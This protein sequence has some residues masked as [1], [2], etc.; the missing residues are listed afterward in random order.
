VVDEPVDLQPVRAR[1][2]GRVDPRP[3]HHDHPQVRHGAPGDRER[4]DHP[5]Q[6]LGAGRRPADRGDAERRA[7]RAGRDRPGRRSDVAGEVEV[8]QRPVADRR[9]SRAERVG[10]QVVRVADEDRPVAQPRVP[11]DVLHHLGVVV[12]G[13]LGLPG[14][15][16]RHRQPADEVG[17]PR[18]RRPL[19]GRV[20][21]QEMVELPGLVADPQVVAFLGDQV[22]EQHEVADQDRV[23]P[24]DRLERVQVVHAGLGVDVRRLGRQ[25]PRGRVHPLAAAGQHLGRR[26]LGQPVHFDAGM[27]PAQRPDDR[28]VALDVAQP[29]RRGQEEHPL[30]PPSPR[31]GGR[32]GRHEVAQQVVD[33]DRPPRV[34]QVPG[35][36]QHDLPRPGQLGHR[37]HLRLRPAPVAVAPDHQD[38]APYGPQQRLG[39][40]P[41][42]H[43]R[44][45]LHA[46]DQHVRV[47][48]PRPG[49]RVLTLLAGMRFV[50]HGVEEEPGERRVVALPEVAVVLGPALVGVQ[51][52]VEVERRAVRRRVGEVRA[53]RGDRRDAADP[54]RVAGGGHQRPPRAR[55]QPGQH[56]LVHAHRVQHREQLRHL[57]V[58]AVRP[59]VD[60]AVRPAV[61]GRV[62][63]HHPDVPGQV[64][65]LRLPVLRV[66]DRPGR[67]QHQRGFA[68][69]GHPV[70]DPDAVVLHETLH[71]ASMDR[72]VA[73]GLQSRGRPFGAT[74]GGCDGSRSGQVDG[75]PRSLRE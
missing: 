32:P 61:A 49:D 13:E 69:A 20:L 39:S 73:T 26:V 52:G 12:G 66:H 47:R 41:V 21:V 14:A 36:G 17:Q 31:R 18:V 60:R 40:G 27:R 8:R 58:V 16:V 71:A 3:G 15:A 56:G 22:G 4:G 25:E 38:R 23:H 11:G 53:G 51:H 30:R 72:P 64:G 63:R 10:D 54:F 35:A 59:G 28:D 19:Q 1:Q 2:A 50:D 42:G 5:A 74:E 75:V 65:H 7:V 67:H 33:L 57:R 48:L 68:G 9:Q 34:R 55:A 46:G 29:D 6:Q 37:R 43:A 62:V 24:A 70:A 45:R 44:G